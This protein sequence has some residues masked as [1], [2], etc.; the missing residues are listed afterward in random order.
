MPEDTEYKNIVKK[1]ATHVRSGV[2]KGTAFWAGDPEFEATANVFHVRIDKWHYDS[3]AQENLFREQDG[4]FKNAY[5]YST[6]VPQGYTIDSNGESV[7]DSANQKLT[8]WTIIREGGSGQMQVFGTS[9]HYQY[10]PPTNPE[11]SSGSSVRPPDTPCITPVPY[12]G[13]QPEPTTPGD[14]STWEASAQLQ[15]LLDRYAIRDSNDRMGRA[16]RA[17]HT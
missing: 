16:K 5:H 17:R 12:P 6:N 8:T 13:Y 10:V 15:F 7:A 9:G 4:K 14:F 2:F 3:D 11:G 1:Y